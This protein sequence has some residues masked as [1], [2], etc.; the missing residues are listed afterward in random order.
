[1]LGKPVCHIAPM[2]MKKDW[3]HQGMTVYPMNHL[4][5]LVSDEEEY[6]A[7]AKEVQQDIEPISV[8]I[9]PFSRDTEQR[10]FIH[11]IIDIISDY[12][13]QNPSYQIVINA[14]SGPSLWQ[15]NLYYTAILMRD[16]ITDFFIF[17][18]DIGD[19]THI[20]LPPL[21]LSKPGETILKILKEADSALS[22]DEIG[23]KYGDATKGLMSRYLTQL[24]K[25]R[26]VEVTR[27]LRTNYYSLTSKG[28]TIAY[29]LRKRE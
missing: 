24:S 22:Q 17:E 1:M 19:P 3:V 6:L 23:K 20:W 15:L 29:G 25:E 9:I 12:T 28:S 10:E 18:K 13:S 5:L 14:T 8:Q 11:K 7:I 27:K 21:K 16:L 4:I 26:L 2:G